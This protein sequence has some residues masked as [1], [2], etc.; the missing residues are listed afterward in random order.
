MHKV[1]REEAFF[2][3]TTIVLKSW[4]KLEG[5]PKVSTSIESTIRKYFGKIDIFRHPYNKMGIQFQ[6]EVSNK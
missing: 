3:C 4:K 1:F 2:Y 5:P 6:K